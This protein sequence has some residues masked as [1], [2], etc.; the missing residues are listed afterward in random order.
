M[1]DTTPVKVPQP[2][3]AEECLE[4]H[5]RFSQLRYV[6]LSNTISPEPPDPVSY[7]WW[8]RRLRLAVSDCLHP[9]YTVA[10][11]QFL[12]CA[13]RIMLQGYSCCPSPLQKFNTFEVT[14]FTSAVTIIYLITLNHIVVCRLRSTIPSASKRLSQYSLFFALLLGVI[15]LHQ[16]KNHIKQFFSCPMPESNLQTKNGARP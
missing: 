15:L 7:Y 6:H 2:F 4:H 5:V 3:Q 8:V 9:H 1:R 13:T 14:F 16:K 11:A 10:Y 12:L